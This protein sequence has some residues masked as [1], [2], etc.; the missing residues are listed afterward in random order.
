MRM[1]LTFD[2]LCLLAHI[3]ANPAPTSEHIRGYD[4]YWT[5]LRRRIGK[6]LL[7]L[8]PDRNK[9]A[10]IQLYEDEIN[11]LLVIA[12]ITWHWGDGPDCGY[13]LYLKLVKAIEGDF[14]WE[15]GE[16]REDEGRSSG[17]T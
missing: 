9:E 14:L 4:W 8:G 13:S 17:N 3:T 10:E 7:S 15:G 1:M 12:P 5:D 6:A 16:Q 11:D 2:E